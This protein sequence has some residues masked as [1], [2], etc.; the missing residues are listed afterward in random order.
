M[1]KEIKL[2]DIKKTT[3]FKNIPPTPTYILV[4]QKL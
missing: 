3:T 4:T 2:L 1:E